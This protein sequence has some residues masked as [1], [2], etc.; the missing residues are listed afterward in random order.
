[1]SAGQGDE[2][3]QGPVAFEP[4]AAPPPRGDCR[5]TQADH[6]PGARCG[7]I[8]RGSPW[9]PGSFCSPPASTPLVLDR[10]GFPQSMSMHGRHRTGSSTMSC[11]LMRSSQSRSS[12]PSVA[13]RG[14]RCLNVQPSDGFAAVFEF[15]T[16]FSSRR[17]CGATHPQPARWVELAIDPVD[18][19]KF[20]ENYDLIV[21]VI[22]PNDATPEELE[23]QAEI[24]AEALR[25]LPPSPMPSSTSSPS[26]TRPRPARSKSD[27][28][29][30]LRR[31]GRHG[32][33]RVGAH[34]HH[35]KP[36]CGC[37]RAR[38]QR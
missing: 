10:E 3:P 5:P 19:T 13:C 6:P 24:T 33:D 8:G 9:S 29:I 25:P 27:G 32:R 30:S 26:P 22:G 23:A 4:C 1:M 34:R 37:R 17:R 35:P 38:L 11:G 36:R 7:A 12:K 14:R 15:E 31:T 28:P 16:T 2:D 20:L 21:T 18:A